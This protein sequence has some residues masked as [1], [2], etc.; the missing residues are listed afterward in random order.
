MPIPDYQQFVD[1]E[2]ITST[3][4]HMDAEKPSSNM[5]FKY[6]TLEIP[7]AFKTEVLYSPVMDTYDIRLHFY[8]D[9]QY[10]TSIGQVASENFLSSGLNSYGMLAAKMTGQV[11]TYLGLDERVAHVVEARLYNLFKNIVSF[12]KTMVSKESNNNAI[13][14]K[15]R[16]LPGVDQLVEPP[17]ECTLL[18]ATLWSLI[19]HLNDFHKEWTREKI[20][21]WID[22]LHDAG[23]I[24][25][26]FSPWGEEPE[27][28]AGTKMFETWQDASA[29]MVK[30]GEIAKK[31]NKAIIGFGAGFYPIDQNDV[32]FNTDIYDSIYKQSLDFD[33]NLQTFSIGKE[34]SDD[35]KD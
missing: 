32:K 29:K 10:H 12:D 27:K 25:A 31:T 28:E 19:Q 24:N 21:D 22:E 9:G 16:Q 13:S 17:C 3:I 23:I 34:E 5:Q 30:L 26:E 2:E 15:S 1:P 14:A 33:L 7:S 8:Y 11:S 20:A 4:Y 35:D 6:Q 18:K